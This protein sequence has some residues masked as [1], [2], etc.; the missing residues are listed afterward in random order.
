[1]LVSKGQR[2]VISSALLQ[3]SN[4]SPVV[5]SLPCSLEE[6]AAHRVPR[7]HDEHRTSKD[8]WMEPLNAPLTSSSPQQRFF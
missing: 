4:P 5:R 2:R 7:E 6:P 8:G 3:C 1:M